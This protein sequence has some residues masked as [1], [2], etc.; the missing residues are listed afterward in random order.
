MPTLPKQLAGLIYQ[1]GAQIYSGLLPIPETE[2]PKVAT[3]LETFKEACENA[4]IG[5]IPTVSLEVTDFIGK[6]VA[7]GMSPPTRVR[8]APPMNEAIVGYLS[9]QARAWCTPNQ[10]LRGIKTS[11][12]SLKIEALQKRLKKDAGQPGMWIVS[13]GGKYG[14][15][16]AEAK[17]STTKTN[18]STAEVNTNVEPAPA[19]LPGETVQPRVLAYIET[20]P[21][22][23]KAQV[24][25][26]FKASPNPVKENHV[27]AAIA[28]MRKSKKITDTENGPYWALPAA[29]AAVKRTAAAGGI[30]D[31]AAAPA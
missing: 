17:T 13:A 20:H 5:S 16:G 23:T 4:L 7:T 27:G 25:A 18:A 15:P 28:R 14:M 21:G 30:G 19:G 2:L 8:G 29:K 9:T 11:R 12:P 1:A 3:A 10:I 22:Y 6:V 24:I 31:G 26:A